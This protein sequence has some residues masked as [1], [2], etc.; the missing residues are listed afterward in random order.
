MGTR[1]HVSSPFNLEIISKTGL[2]SYNIIYLCFPS[3]EKFG[4]VQINFT[5]PLRS[6]Q[7]KRSALAYRD[8]ILNRV[9]L[10]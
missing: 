1:I 7:L 9:S 10:N 8:I 6:F 3:S 4:L 5:D 2:S